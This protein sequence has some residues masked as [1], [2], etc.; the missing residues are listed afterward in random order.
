MLKE[1]RDPYVETAREFYK[2]PSIVKT[3]PDGS[4]HPKYRIFKSFAHGTHYLGTPQ[5]LAQRLGLLTHEAERTQR[6]YLGKYKKIREWQ[7]DFKA[8]LISKRFVENIFGNRCYFFD[9]PDDRMLRA[10]IAWLPASTVALYIN[11]IW[12]RIY[13]EHPQTW[14]LLQ[15]HDSLVGQFPAH[16]REECLTQIRD[17]AKIILPYEDPLIIPVGIKT[18]TKSWGDCK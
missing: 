14:V 2:D 8:K 18:S 16:R 1:G 15:V 10:A 4:E 3:R 9:R 17:A 7:E 5:G 12:L 11:R 6:W 13:E